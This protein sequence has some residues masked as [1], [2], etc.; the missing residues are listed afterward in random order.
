VAPRAPHA[1]HRIYL[2]ASSG[3]PI[4]RQ[5]LWHSG[6]GTLLYDTPVRYPEGGRAPFPARFA[7]F[8][9]DGTPTTTD[10]DGQVTWASDTTAAVDTTATGTYVVV[11]SADDDDATATLALDPGGTVTWSDETPA[12][13][14]QLTAFVHANRAKTFVRTLA[15]DLLWLD[16]PLDVQVNVEGDCNAFSDGDA[17]YFFREGV[18]CHNAARLPD[19]VYH[20]FGHS[21]HAH[22]LIAGAGF[23]DAALS[24]GASDYLAAAITGD[25]AV[26]RGFWRTDGPLRHIDPDDHEARWPE[27][28]AFDDHTTG[29]IVAGA[30]WDLRSELVADLGEEE[31]V[32]LADQLYHAVLLRASDIPSS[33][34]EVLAADDDDGDLENGTPH[35]CAI[36]T[37]FARH[38]LADPAAVGAIGRPITTDLR[39][40]IEVRAPT[41][42]CDA[43]EVESMRVLWHRRD[44]PDEGGA[45][46]M[47]RTLTGFTAT[48]PDQPDG[49]VLGYQI[50]VALADGTTALRPANPADPI[51][52]LFHGETVPLYCTGLETSPWDDGWER[53]TQAGADQGDWEWGTPRRAPGSGDPDGAFTG[54]RALGTDLGQLASDG[55]YDPEVVSYV[56]LPPVAVPAGAS[57]VRLQ[58]RRWLTVEDSAFDQA[59]ISSNGAPLWTNANG[60]DG[61][62]HHRDREWRFQDLD[63][64]DTVFD[65]EVVVRFE[66]AADGGFQMGGWNIDDVCV[67]AV[68]GTGDG[69][70][71]GGLRRPDDGGCGCRAGAAPGQAAA[72]LL[73][74]ALGQLRRRRR[75]RVP[76]QRAREQHQ[77]GDRAP[78][79]P[80]HD[81]G[82]DDAAPRL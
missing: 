63:L 14:A 13:D 80:D 56:D 21:F 40:D 27:D 7:D 55:Q 25:P 82:V 17:L 18:P 71:D 48:L 6:Q 23:F 39:V 78:A 49:T 62:L 37:A 31:G 43:L 70:G 76:G 73:L 2:D 72:L 66:I 57:A 4:A 51:Y 29:L 35:G 52:Q 50:E 26:G 5:P 3:R 28:I 42:E 15:P 20:E 10:T 53:G 58:Y 74:G 61:Q 11:T 34:V 36:Q 30:L 16:T 9:A 19:I 32:A 38:G 79:E 64:T 33:Y 47:E 46:D 1:T 81:A 65:G 24:E 22:T 69:E 59:T 54:E 68:P 45:V 8:T 77:D 12:I 44:D 75:R 60:E 41:V 67:V